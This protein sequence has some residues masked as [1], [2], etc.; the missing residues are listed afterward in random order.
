[1][2]TGLVLHV[3]FTGPYTLKIPELRIRT[4]EAHDNGVIKL[5]VLAHYVCVRVHGQLAF[6]D[7]TIPPRTFEQREVVACRR[8]DIDLQR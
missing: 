7:S 3:A 4:I 2:R 1:M 8:S 5:A 6:M